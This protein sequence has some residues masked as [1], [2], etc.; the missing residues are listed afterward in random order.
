MTARDAQIVE[1]QAEAMRS[2]KEGSVNGVVKGAEI[3]RDKISGTK[4]LADTEEWKKGSRKDNL[5]INGEFLE[6]W[7]LR[8]TWGRWSGPHWPLLEMGSNEGRARLHLRG[9][10]P[11]RTENLPERP[12]ETM[13]GLQEAP[14]PS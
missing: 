12:P 8:E 4:L 11:W 2:V 5:E 7:T 3:G 13:S 14:E 10:C 6:A 1:V 9:A